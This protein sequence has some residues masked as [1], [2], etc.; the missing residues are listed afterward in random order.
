MGILGVPALSMHAVIS[1]LNLHNPTK[2]YLT[3]YIYYSFT[4][5]LN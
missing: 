1:I 2:S 4:V 5:P 3:P